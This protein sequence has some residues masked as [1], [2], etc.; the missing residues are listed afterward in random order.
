MNAYILG[1]EQNAIDGLQAKLK[2]IFS[3]LVFIISSS[4]SANLPKVGDNLLKPPALLVV[5][6][7]IQR[8]LQRKDPSGDKSPF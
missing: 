1:D 5:A 3:E 4:T 8:C 2:K 6:D 7:A